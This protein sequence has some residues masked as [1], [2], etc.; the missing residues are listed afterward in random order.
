MEIQRT[1]VCETQSCRRRGEVGTSR[2]KPTAFSTDSMST[3]LRKPP[4]AMNVAATWPPCPTPDPFTP[5][6]YSA[7]DDVVSYHET[8]R[9]LRRRP[10]EGDRH[11]RGV[12]HRV[13]RNHQV[14]RIAVD[15]E[16]TAVTVEAFGPDVDAADD[17]VRKSMTRVMGICAP[18]SCPES[19][20]NP[21]PVF[22]TTL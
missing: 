4:P 16:T 8:R 1:G 14:D 11:V 9:R 19:G 20:G 22:L 5:S 3:L 6:H 17:V 12:E 21:E 2:I 15:Q 7:A 18:T 10:A 13:V